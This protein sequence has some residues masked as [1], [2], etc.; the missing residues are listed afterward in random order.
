MSTSVLAN[1]ISF[2]SR[3][4]MPTSNLGISI[5]TRLL[6]QSMPTSVSTSSPGESMP[7]LSLSVHA[8]FQ[9]S[10]CPYRLGLSVSP[11]WLRLGQS[12]SASSLS[13]SRTTS[14]STSLAKK[15][16]SSPLLEELRLTSIGK[17]MVC[18]SPEEHDS[19]QL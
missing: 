4:V 9:V 2:K 5:P 1:P 15:H 17:L 14:I 16:Y 19:V 10:T 11:C 18:S 13:Q 6:G 8:N 7:A 12:T 3:L